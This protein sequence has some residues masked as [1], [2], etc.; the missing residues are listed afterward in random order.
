M[1]QAEILVIE[2]QQDRA[3]LHG[4]EQLLVIPGITHAKFF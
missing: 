2:R 1:K 4:H 3:L